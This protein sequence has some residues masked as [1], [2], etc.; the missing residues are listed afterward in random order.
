MSRI[1]LPRVIGHQE[2]FLYPISIKS[3]CGWGGLDQKVPSRPSAESFA[4]SQRQKKEC[5]FLDQVATL[6]HL[7]IILGLILNNSAKS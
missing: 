3:G 4:V 1:L 5:V 2:A 7:V 6:S